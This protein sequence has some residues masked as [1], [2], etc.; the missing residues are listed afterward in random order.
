MKM[1]FII[2]LKN[3]VRLKTW[4]LKEAILLGVKFKD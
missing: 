2:C 3:R 4:V 1:D